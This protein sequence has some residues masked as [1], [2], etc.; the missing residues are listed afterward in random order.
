METIINGVFYLLIF[1]LGLYAIGTLGKYI[2]V[3]KDR[4]NDDDMDSEHYDILNIVRVL[5]DAAEQKF[6]DELSTT[7]GDK[8]KY[9][10]QIMREHFPDMDSSLIEAY[11]EAAVKRMN[12]KQTEHPIE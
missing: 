4:L 3:L 10:A 8:F 11:I 2:E 1:L 12:D 5:V 9:V 7:G 6:K